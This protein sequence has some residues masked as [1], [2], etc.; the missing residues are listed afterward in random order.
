LLSYSGG[1]IAAGEFVTFTVTL[2]VAD[3]VAPS[4]TLIN[5]ATITNATTL[6]GDVTG[7]RDN[8]DPDN[9]GS[10]IDS[11]SVTVRSNSLAGNVYF[12]A[13]NDGIF[14]DAAE[15]G[16]EGV[17]VR[18]QGTDHLGNAVDI[19]IQTLA[20]GSYLFDDLRPGTY[21]I[22][23]TQP[24]TAVNGKDYLDGTD[25]IGT[26]GGNDSTND[27]FSNIVLSTGVETQGTG[28]NFGELEEA[29]LS[30]FVFHDSNNNG[31]RDSG[32]VGINGVGVTH[33]RL[34]RDE[35]MQMDKTKMDRWQ[36]AFH[37]TM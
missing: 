29:E 27:E 34:H 28:N 6:E 7:E 2:D 13:N 24:T 9:D 10:D 20:D 33:S 31:V 18:L 32:E 15:S 23:E 22:T 17:N 8:P 1:S 19:T 36:T 3:T 12:D 26:Q 21:R 25:T 14:S 11:D 16:I 5:T 30:G 4:E 35:I 37:P